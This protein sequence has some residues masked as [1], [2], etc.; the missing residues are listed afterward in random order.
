MNVSRKLLGLLILLGLAG[1]IAGPMVLAQPQAG[2]TPR[3]YL[4]IVSSPRCSYEFLDDFSDP[5]SGWPAGLV[6]VTGE[7]IGLLEYVNGEYRI[8]SNEAG[9]GYLFRPLAPA[10][11]NDNYEVEVDA[12]FELPT[13]D[14]LVGLVFGAVIEGT[15]VPRYYLF[16]IEPETQEFRLI[17]RENGVP[18]DLVGYTFSAAINPGTAVNHLKVI[19]NGADITLAVNDVI[20]GT[21]TDS[22][23]TGPTYTGLGFRLRSN[24]PA[25]SSYF[26]NYAICVPVTNDAV[27]AAS[28]TDAVPLTAADSFKFGE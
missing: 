17:R 3:A 12:R 24:L 10:F 7:E 11:G 6:F 21:W 9:A 16:E 2:L 18:T 1:A 23:I 13:T 20:L 28:F 25:A 19:R 15:E 14:G 4:P 27:S 26:D 22:A 8:F 5:D